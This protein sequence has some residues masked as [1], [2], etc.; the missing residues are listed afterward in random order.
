[1][2][3]KSFHIASIVRREHTS[4][5]FNFHAE[6]RDYRYCRIAI[7]KGFSVHMPDACC[8][9]RVRGRSED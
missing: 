4:V 8:I 1:M 7:L 2:C 5:H 6:Q 9:S 3:R